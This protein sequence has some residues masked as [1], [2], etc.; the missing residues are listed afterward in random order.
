MSKRKCFRLSATCLCTLLAITLIFFVLGTQAEAKTIKLKMAT[1]DGS[2]GTPAADTLDMWA[3]LIE[4]KS[5]GNIKVEVYYQGELGGQR[6]TFDQ[7]IM[8]NIHMMLTWPLV[9]HDKRL[10]VLYTPYM[11]TTWDSA[12]KAYQPGGWFNGLI[13]GL[14]KDAGL[15]FFGPWPEGFGGIASRKHYATTIDEVKQSGLKIR[16][17]P[18]FPQPLSVKALGY[19][20]AVIDWSEVYTAIQTGVVDG[21]AGNV[22]FWDYE[23]FRD[24]LDYYVHTKH[25]FRVALL[26]MNLDAWDNLSP[27]NKAVVAEAAEA[28]VEK[29][30]K[31]A[32]VRD[33]HYRQEAI[34]AGI[35]YIAIPEKDLAPT[36]TAVRKAVWPEMDKVVGKEIMDVVRENA[37][38][39]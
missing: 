4:K 22:I 38:Q 20:A 17:A 30:F 29:A 18:A 9:S 2:K 1:A 13:D 8:G 12:L 24:V 36:I 21:D 33:E 5:N 23:Y 19:Q 34:K 3:D 25:E 7:F 16:T 28:V 35:E 15:K 26:A 6:E 27:E 31:D 10:S 11:F 14:F 32:K 37:I 39:Y